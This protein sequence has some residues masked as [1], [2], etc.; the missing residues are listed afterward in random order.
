MRRILLLTFAI[1]FLS[2]SPTWAASGSDDFERGDVTPVDG[3]WDSLTAALF[4]IVSGHVQS[5]DASGDTYAFF[6][7]FT[8]TADQEATITLDAF[9]GAGFGF[10]G[11]ILRGQD[12]SNMYICFATKNIGGTST[13]ISV[14]ESGGLSTLDSESSTTWAATDTL[15]CKMEGDNINA[16]RNGSGTPLASGNDSTFSGGSVGMWITEEVT[17]ADTAIEEFSATDVAAAP[18]STNKRRA[19]IV[20]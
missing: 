20:Q 7:A 10:A 8:P 18:G 9:T 12:A 11:A 5:N 19:V 1:F 16:Y 17:L 15:R 3:S 14:F 2:S 4:A 6:T 13:Q